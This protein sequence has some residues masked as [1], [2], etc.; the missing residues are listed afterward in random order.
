MRGQ[1]EPGL[2]GS[3]RG[4]QHEHGVAVGPRLEGEHDLLV[5]H[6]DAVGERLAVG[7][8]LE[9]AEAGA[10]ALEAG[11][12]VPGHVGRVRDGSTRRADRAQQLVGAAVAE[13]LGDGGLL[14]H[15]QPV[16]RAAGRE[17]ERVAHVEQPSVRGD[18]RLVGDVGDPRGRHGPQHGRVAQ[19]AVGLLEVGLEQV[20][21]LAGALGASQ[22]VLAQLR[23]PVTGEAAP[24]GQ[25]AGAQALSERL[26]AGHRAR[27]EDAEDDLDVVG[28]QPPGLR[29]GAHAVVQP[30]PGVPHRVP[31]PVG[32][33]RDILARRVQQQQVQVAAGRELAPAVPA[34][35]DEGSARRRAAC[36]GEQPAQPLV[37]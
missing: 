14:L 9:P 26:V 13:P 2:G 30:E 35:G 37:G 20:R 16:G 23:Q 8:G 24:V 6:D 32:E 17:V 31:E 1:P 4:A 15:E 11:H 25:H 33:R 7:P 29:H 19:A 5:L 36:E 12:A 34:D 21:E 3:G 18:Q 22:D 28:G 10:L 27:V